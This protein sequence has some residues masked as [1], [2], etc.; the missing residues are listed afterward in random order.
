MEKTII[1]FW[2]AW[3]HPCRVY[4]P[5]FEKVK[6]ELQSDKIQFIEVN[7]EDDPTNLTRRHRVVG[8][9]HTIVLENGEETKAQSGVLSEEQLKEFI[10]N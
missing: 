9:P 10:L 6:Q 3:C 8:I 1:K 2:G 4:A 5:T 7:V